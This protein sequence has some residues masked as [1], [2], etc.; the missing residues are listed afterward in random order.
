MSKHH[1]PFTNIHRVTCDNLYQTFYRWDYPATDTGDT[2]GAVVREQKQ[3]LAPLYLHPIL[4]LVSLH[5]AFTSHTTY[6][7]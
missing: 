3:R 5:L 2:L 6:I 1:D 7:E 4:E